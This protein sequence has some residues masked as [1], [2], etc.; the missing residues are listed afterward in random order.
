MTAVLAWAR[1]DVRRH[2]RSLLLLAAMVALSTGVVAAAFTAA[3]RGDTALARLDER[4]LPATVLVPSYDA[5]LDLRP[6]QQLPYVDG[7]MRFAQGGLGLVSDGFQGTTSRQSPIDDQAYTDVEKPVVIAGRMF[8]PA[9]PDEA[10]VTPGWPATAHLGI[11]DTVNIYLAS[12]EQMRTG[13]IGQP[14][15]PMVALRIVGIVKAP[16][17]LEWPGST[18][19]VI[20]SPGLATRYP[21]VWD[22]SSRPGCTCAWA[23]P[24]AAF[25]RL[26]DGPADVGRLTG[27]LAR[28]YPDVDFAILNLAQTQAAYQHDIAV[29]SLGITAFAIAAL[30]AALVVVGQAVVRQV[31]TRRSDLQVG[32]LLG[33]TAGQAAVVGA[34]TIGTAAVAG[35]GVGVVLAALTSRWTPLGLARVAEPTPGFLV[36]PWPLAAV[37][38]TAV[39]GCT[40]VA[41]LATLRVHSSS[42]ETVGRREPSAVVRLAARANLPVPVQVGSRYALEAR[43]GSG[44]LPTLP[45]LVATVVAVTGVVATIVIGNGVSDALGHR[46]RYGQ[47]FTA[48]SSVGFGSKHFLNPAKD[49]QALEALPYVDGVMLPRQSTA[50]AV[51]HS[52]SVGML[53]YDPSTAK[54]LRVTVLAGR[55]VQS[56][57]EVALAP[58]ALRALHASLGDDVTFSGSAGSRTFRIVGDV[59]TPNT[60]P[61]RYDQGGW[62][63]DGGYDAIFK[64][65]DAH[66]VLVSTVPSAGDGELLWTRLET[67]VSESTNGVQNHGGQPFNSLVSTTEVTTPLHQIRLYPLALAV[68]LMLLA[69]G[70]LAHVVV[71]T[72]RTRVRDVGVLRALGMTRASASLI[73]PTQVLVVTLVGL[74][75]GVPLGLAL[76]RTAWRGFASVMPLQYVAPGFS[77]LDVLLLAPVLALAIAVVPAILL[78]R[79]PLAPILRAE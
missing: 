56:D 43:Q 6:L 65:F 57:D 58:G 47:D 71:T 21:F 26:H 42:G 31:A 73:L 41:F 48:T 51:D 45:A 66:W 36:D 18:P 8:D 12:R 15:G 17:Y 34:L 76:G 46:E 35:A 32:R 2:W 13:N 25:V 14:E 75:A 59:L 38:A 77:G 23:P 24:I 30:V 19:T 69:L 3:H 28:L 7:F 44:S 61:A 39:L 63:T 40:A 53:S 64:G 54:P 22:T 74:V 72:A 37:F 70:A 10:V 60:A 11:G 4:S 78:A 67:D 49:Q 29:Q 52:V 9:A 68:F 33:V 55:M 16:E 62:L 50:T 5:H 27:D 20:P 79:R 1:L